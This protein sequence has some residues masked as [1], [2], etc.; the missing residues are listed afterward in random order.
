MLVSII[1][2]ILVIIK[3]RSTSI[4]F[5]ELTLKT[6]LTARCR[7]LSWKPRKSVIENNF[8]ILNIYI[9]ICMHSSRSGCMCSA[10][11]LECTRAHMLISWSVTRTAAAYAR[12]LASDRGISNPRTAAYICLLA[13]A[14]TRQTTGNLTSFNTY[15]Y[16]H[17]H[18]QCIYEYWSWVLVE[19]KR[20]CMYF[21]SL[22]PRAQLTRSCSEDRARSRS[23]HFCHIPALLA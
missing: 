23:T 11:E 7:S 20:A 6:Y 19:L 2:F 4:R 21:N 14:S 22:V 1:K 15:I 18:A 12:S 9:Y 3:L 16:M 10:Q 8:N 5:Q 13:I 17:M